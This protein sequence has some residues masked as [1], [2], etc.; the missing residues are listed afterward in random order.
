ML[1]SRWTRQRNNWPVWGY[2]A[3]IYKIIYL[4]NMIKGLNRQFRQSAGISISDAL[5]QIRIE[6]ACRLLRQTGEPAELIAQKVG[7]S[8]IKYFFVIF[9]KLTGSTPRQYRE[10][11]ES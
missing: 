3:E 4:A 6:Q 5:H 8:N 1:P 11:A 2:M 9:K 7:Y 10:A